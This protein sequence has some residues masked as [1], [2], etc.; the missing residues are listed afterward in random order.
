VAKVARAVFGGVVI[1]ALIFATGGAG[2]FG[3]IGTVGST[4]GVSTFAASLITGGLYGGALYGISSLLKPPQPDLSSE[5]GREIHLN[6]D[7]LAPRKI[8]YGEA[9]TSGVLRRPK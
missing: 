8:F 2:L 1:G 5:F 7:P 3:L 6:G 9:W 4:L